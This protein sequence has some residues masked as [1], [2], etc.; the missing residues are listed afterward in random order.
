MDA[1]GIARH[2]RAH[3]APGVGG[4]GASMHA[5]DV[6]PAD[7]L[8]IERADRRAVVRADGG[9]ARDVEWGVHLNSRAKLGEAER[10]RKGRQW[11]MTEVD[12]ERT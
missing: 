4:V 9:A 8:D 5:P 7:H 6:V 3:D 2:F 1:L 10:L 12:V 11:Q